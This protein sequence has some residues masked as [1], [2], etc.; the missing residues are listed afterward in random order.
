MTLVPD[1]A[2]ARHRRALWVLVV[3][4]VPVN[5][6][7]Q[8]QHQVTH[9]ARLGHVQ[10]M[11]R[12]LR[13]AGQVGEEEGVQVVLGRGGHSQ[14]EQ[15][16]VVAAA[17]YDVVVSTVHPAGHRQGALFDEH[18]HGGGQAVLRDKV[19]EDAFSRQAV[20]LELHGPVH[21]VAPVLPVLRVRDA[22]AEPAPERAGRVVLH[23]PPEGHQGPGV[24]VKV[25]VLA[26]RGV[27]AVAF[28]R[29]HHLHDGAA[30]ADE[31]DAGAVVVQS[32]GVATPKQELAVK[33]ERALPAHGLARGGGV[34]DVQHVVPHGVA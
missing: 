16:V 18:G 24:K 28:P 17:E 1:V 30:A 9:P 2:V 25:P 13:Q 26:Q 5:V 27:E 19:E 10:E 3:A 6:L 7:L 11:G 15:I 32:A 4:E 8:V 31:F 21:V 20:A 12:P 29:P 34:A 33:G 23:H 22:H 14:A